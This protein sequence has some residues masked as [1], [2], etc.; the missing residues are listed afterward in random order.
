M[1]PV[2]VEAGVLAHVQL[3]V[4]GD[5]QSVGPAVVPRE[6][7]S[8]FGVVV[9]DFV[10]EFFVSGKVVL[11]GFLSGTLVD[12]IFL[13]ALDDCREL[14]PFVVGLLALRVQIV[15][16]AVLVALATLPGKLHSLRADDRR[17]AHVGL[18]RLLVN[19]GGDV[20]HVLPDL[21]IGVQE[22]ALELGEPGGASGLSLL[23]M[24]RRLLLKW[25]F[26]RVIRNSRSGLEKRVLF[27]GLRR[28]ELVGKFLVL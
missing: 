28:G 1:T 18:L 12:F 16:L 27:E 11:R 8:G 3:F 21:G 25:V 7:V 22:V 15:A 14:N 17:H 6:E 5:H 13:H 26:M 4:R 23:G 19:D 9:R 10:L 24:Q 2:L 20:D